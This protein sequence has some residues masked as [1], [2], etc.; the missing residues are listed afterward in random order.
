MTTTQRTRRWATTFLFA[1]L[2]LT[3]GACG[4][5][6]ASDTSVPR[7]EMTLSRVDD[8][9]ANR[10]WE[11]TRT[12]LQTLIAQA[13]G[14]LED[15]TLGQEQADRIQAAAARLLS[16]L[17]NPPTQSPSPSP[18]SEDPE[19]TP[20]EDDSDEAQ[21]RREEVAEERREEAEERREEAE[22]QEAEDDEEDADDDH[23]DDE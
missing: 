7:L 8:S 17:P 4:E 5:E 3:T 21:E 12:A 10:N 11:A 16:E 1:T 19:T 2:V 15:G 18:P 20:D 13:Q 9:L 22:E 6:P 14:A 23:D